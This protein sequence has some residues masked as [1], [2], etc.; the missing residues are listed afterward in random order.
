MGEKEKIRQL[1]RNAE[2][3]IKADRFREANQKLLQA[4]DMAKKIHDEVLL[5]QVFELLRKSGCFV[6]NN[7]SIVLDPLRTAGRILD[8][9]GGGE[10][11]IGKLNGKQVISIDINQRELEETNNEALKIIMDATDIKFLPNTFDVC[12]AFFSLMHIPTSKHLEVF[13]EAYRVLKNK[14]RFLIWDSKIPQMEN[15]SEFIVLLKVKLPDE[16]IETGYGSRWHAQNIEYFTELARQIK[17]QVRDNWSQGEVF[18][19]ELLK[20]GE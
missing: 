12:T 19:L 17:F 7:Q 20:T 10:G 3:N 14:G 1:L 9:G 5:N 18:Y 11:I 4:F 13:K 8:I 2:L 15:Y 16:E 6:V